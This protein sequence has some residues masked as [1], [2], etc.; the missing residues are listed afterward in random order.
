MAGTFATEKKAASGSSQAARYKQVV[1]GQSITPSDKWGNSLGTVALEMDET[2][3][4][5]LSTRFAFAGSSRR[6]CRRV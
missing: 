3:S 4:C 2:R 5:D 1:I 6:V